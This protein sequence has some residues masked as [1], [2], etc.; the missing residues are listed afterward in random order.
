[1]MGRASGQSD[2]ELQAQTAVVMILR[3]FVRD[4]P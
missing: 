3:Q 1:M 4:R 2:L